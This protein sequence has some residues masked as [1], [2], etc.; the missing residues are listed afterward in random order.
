[1]KLTVLPDE[2]FSCHS[3]TN[4]CRYWW[5]IE[6]LPGE[7]ERIE[8]QSWTP[9]LRPAGE[10]FTVRGDRTY[11]AHR[12]D[13]ACVFL[14]EKTGLCTIHATFGGT[15]KPLGCQLYP[16]QISPTFPGEATITTRHDCPTVRKNQGAPHA[17]ELPT[18]RKFAGQLHLGA[19]FTDITCCNLSR[20]Q[21]T[22]V[23]EFISTLMN[24]FATDEQ[25]AIFIAWLADWISTLSVDQ[26]D[27]GALAQT[28]GPLKQL[29]ESS[30][31]VA[32]RPDASGRTATG[33]KIKRPGLLARL[34]FRTL[35]ALYLRRDED[36]LDGRAN[37]FGRMIA[38]LKVVLGFG[39][40]RGL[41]VQHPD[42]SLKKAKLFAGHREHAPFQLLWRVVRTKLE[43][44]Q[45]M[46]QANGG[47]D[48]LE[49]LRSLALLQPL[50]LAT[51]RYAS[52]NRGATEIAE[53]DIDYAVGVIE[54]S[55]GRQAVLKQNFVRSIEKLLMDHDLF[56]RLVMTV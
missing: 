53:Q 28:F 22:A 52:A 21:I 1:V 11:L 17:D 18:L 13:G 41:G 32:A 6:C 35:L 44:F 45:F 25:R 34:A 8:R 48:F 38:M 16:F 37:R 23:V 40:F 43:S 29:I 14:N 51:A 19:H 46:G 9:E 10:W 5:H 27:R 36:V 55:F 50:V 3:C 4:C 2:R 26:L 39:S 12:E 47:K 24:G 33:V 31:P 42:G 7:R 54:H 15:I 49:G 30:T 56:V 20:D